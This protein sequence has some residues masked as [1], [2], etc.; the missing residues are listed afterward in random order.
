MGVTIDSISPGDG[1]NF[2]KAGDTVTMV[3]QIGSRSVSNKYERVCA[4]CSVHELL[5]TQLVSI[6]VVI[7]YLHE[8]L[9]ME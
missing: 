2:P 7:T 6:S 8:T 9:Y 5:D 4:P 3:R 1:K